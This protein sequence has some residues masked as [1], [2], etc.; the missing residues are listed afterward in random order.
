MIK[1]FLALAISVFGAVARAQEKPTSSL[2]EAVALALKQNPE[3]LAARRQVEQ[4]HGRKSQASSPDQPELSFSWEKIPPSGSFSLAGDRI[5]EIGQN[6]ELPHKLLL[7][8]SAAGRD[9]EIAYENLERAKVVVAAQVKKTYYQVYFQQKQLESLEFTAGLLRQ[10]L[11]ATLSKYQAGG[12]AYF[13][14]V[15]AKVEVAKTEN[16]II[17]A[18][19]ELTSAKTDFNLVLGRTGSEDFDLTDKPFFVPYVKSK[20]ETVRE[21]L[22]KSRALKIAQLAKEREGRNLKLACWSL[23]P[24]LKLTGGFQS[25][26]GGEFRPN[27]GVGFSLPL[28]WWGPKGGITE[29]RASL[30]ISEIRQEALNRVIAGEIERRYT[31]VKAAENQMSLFE[32]SLLREVDEELKAGINAYQ[33]NQI[34]ALNLLDIYRTVKTT[35]IEYYKAFLNYLSALV[36]LETAGEEK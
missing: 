26:A 32:K 12:L 33:Y 16:E 31:L 36:D 14:V 2:E 25:E 13:E 1:A 9:V 28:W 22:K 7:R 18:R 3:V 6:L 34:E 27:V 5:I 19:A 35:R 11:E 4:A 8:R 30:Q 21:L 15:R 24:D 29:N 20:D 17:G 23:V 10:F